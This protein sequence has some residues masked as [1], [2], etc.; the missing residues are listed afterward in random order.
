[1]ARNWNRRGVLP[2][3]RS[4]GIPLFTV[5][6]IKVVADYSWFIVVVLI[7]WGLSFGWFPSYLPDR[8]P[9]QYALLGIIT[10]FF[11][12]ASVFIHELSHSVVAI[13]N[14]I[15]VRRITLFLFGGVAEILREP[16]DPRT[17]L[18]IAIA[19]PAMSAAIAAACWTTYFALNARGVRPGLQLAFNYLAITN[20]FLLVFNLLP[21]LPLDGGRVFR[22]LLWKS[23]RNV[24]TATRIAS[25]VGKAL[26]GILFAAGVLSLVSGWSARIGIWLVLIALFLR[27]AAD[28]SYRQ[29]LL[30]E[31]TG[32]VRISSLMSTSVVTVPPDITLAQLIDAYLLR[33]HFTSYPVV[34]EGTPT[35]LIT[36]GGVKKVPRSRWGETKVSEVMLPLVAET[37]VSPDDGIPTALQ[38]MAATGLTRLPVLDGSGA[39]A[40]IV[41]R[42]DIMSYLQIRAD[43]S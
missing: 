1:M 11:F 34:S 3:L 41:S 32:S 33:Y 5:Y 9:L 40:G 30:R 6:G 21:G 10:A 20:T 31:R 29:V 42:R 7:V 22:A 8:S 16:S 28:A 39:L 18:K 24:A 26:A 19:G 35:G 23:T 12:F 27:Q 4:R 25:T 15:P 13:R 2:F 14:G 36:I 43:L 17:E 37:S 38:K